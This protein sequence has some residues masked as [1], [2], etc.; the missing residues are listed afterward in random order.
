MKNMKNHFWICL[1]VLLL[2][3]LL[4]AALLPSCETP[5]QSSGTGNDETDDFD[6]DYLAELREN[7]SIFSAGMVAGTDTVNS[8]ETVATIYFPEAGELE[9][10]WEAALVRG[11]G[12]THNRLFRIVHKKADG[13]EV[14]PLTEPPALAELVIGGE[15]G[16]RLAFGHY[17]VRVRVRNEA[18]AAFRYPLT[19]DV[20]Y[21]PPAF[22]AAPG[23]Y[24]IV[25]KDGS[26]NYPTSDMK[27]SYPDNIPNIKDGST[28]FAITW[29][30]RTTATSYTVEVSTDANFTD[31]ETLTDSPTDYGNGILGMEMTTFNSAALPN[32]T[33][34][35]ARVSAASSSGATP[36]SPAA[37]R[38]TSAPM[39]D[40][41]YLNTNDEG[42][43]QTTPVAG[44]KK[45]IPSLHDCGG[46]GDYY[47]FSPTTVKYWFGPGGGYDYLGDVVYHEAYDV[48]AADNGRFPNEHKDQASALG[49]PAGV[50]VIKYREGRVP[51]TLTAN[52]NTS[53]K[54][55]RYGAVYYWGAGAVKQG[56]SSN[57]GRKEASIVNQWRGY[58]ETVTYEEAIDKFTCENVAMFLGLIPEPY[59]KEF[60]E[61]VR[62][63]PGIGEGAYSP[64]GYYQQ[65]EPGHEQTWKNP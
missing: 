39:P 28:K 27:M 3:A 10:P 48:T 47:R 42:D 64:D 22:Q 63:E 50:F 23:M 25:A 43:P 51:S 58:A 21:S 9:G 29:P 62:Y 31:K 33:R 52:D 35:W 6:A 18:G 60:P 44:E 32:N 34:Y 46:Y 36:F 57:A 16:E 5:T 26:G 24:P 19:F 49:L 14:D 17:S 54:K 20:T 45:Q 61:R 30:R 2:A 1:A 38:K 55:K 37:N 15:A 12:D 8:G 53:G 65:N 4:P 7:I 59:Y 56:S 40:Y 13:T 41:F 11:E